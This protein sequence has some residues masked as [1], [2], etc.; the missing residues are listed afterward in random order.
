MQDFIQLMR[1]LVLHAQIIINIVNLFASF[2]CNYFF[3][4]IVIVNF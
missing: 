1:E 2:N 4:E 3:N